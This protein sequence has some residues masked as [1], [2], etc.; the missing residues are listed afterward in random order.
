M[1]NHIS[2][3]ACLPF[4]ALLAAIAL[5]PLLV[6]R[7]WEK[8]QNKAV[9]AAL[10]TIPVFIFLINGLQRELWHALEE[11]L[12]FMIMIGSLFVISGGI[13]IRGDLRATPLVNTGFL[14]A[15]SLLANLIGTTGASVLLIRPLLRTNSERVRTKHIPVF[16]I[17]LVANIGGALTPLGDPPLFLGYLRGVP[18]TWN[19]RL[20]PMWLTALAFLLTIFYIWDRRCYRREKPS[21]IRR[22]RAESS[23]LRISG[24]INVFNLLIIVAAVFFQVPSPFREIIMLG[25]TVLSWTVTERRIRAAN[26][27]TWH[28]VVE[29]AILFAAIFITMKPVMLL[30][31]AHGAA[32]GITR[33][34]QYFWLVGGLSSFLDNAPTYVTFFGLAAS[35]TQSLGSGGMPVVAGVRGDLLAAISCGAVFMGANTYIGNGPNFMVKAIAEKAGFQVPHFFEYMIYSAL[36]LL[37]LFIL[38]TFLFFGKA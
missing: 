8:N 6:P 36:I 9:I 13:L 32:L 27:F 18:F 14:L 35:V 22:D 21:D 38:I 17:F 37:P 31:A 12:S 1:T 4:G 7:L 2:P 10:L 11:Y 20:F 34:W 24:I 5:L 16:F 28:P 19:L 23:P 29:V 25:A 26:D 30:L 3:L 15:G 33:P